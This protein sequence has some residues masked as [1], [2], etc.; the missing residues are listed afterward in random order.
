MA[1]IE[2]V[3]LGINGYGLEFEFNKLPLFR[4]K[5]KSIT[6]AGQTIN[7]PYKKYKDRLEIDL[8]LLFLNLLS[9]AN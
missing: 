9:R 6:Y 4:R 2:K 8:D 5:A 7:L 1:K 3:V